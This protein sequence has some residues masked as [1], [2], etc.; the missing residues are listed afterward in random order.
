MEQKS[1]KFSENLEYLAFEH[2]SKVSVPPPSP[3]T[4]LLSYGYV[5]KNKEIYRYEYLCCKNF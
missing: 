1:G 2:F 3:L 5:L 4:V